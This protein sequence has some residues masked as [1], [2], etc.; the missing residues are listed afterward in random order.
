MKR[1]ARA[2]KLVGVLLVVGILLALAAIPAGAE[3]SLIPSKPNLVDA[4]GDAN[5]S[6]SL[7]QPSP[8][9]VPEADILAGWITADRTSISVH[10]LLAASPEGKGVD[11]VMRAVRNPH[12]VETDR[13]FSGRCLWFTA[14]ITNEEAGD[15]YG[16]FFD[17][18]SNPGPLAEVS[19][20]GG[21]S[22]PMTVEVL[23]LADGR[24]IVTASLSRRF[25]PLLRSGKILDHIDARSSLYRYYPPGPTVWGRV[26]A[27]DT[28]PP[29]RD[30][31]M[32]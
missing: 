30:F 22:S 12:P 24:A 29:G 13:K 25:S 1:V 7:D 2:A 9:S 10:W 3:S 27:W 18:C 17:G 8:V 16:Y 20:S 31:R 21:F 5:G 15:P 32:P 28:T 4:A 26:V 11:L 23:E 14:E 6:D 19:D